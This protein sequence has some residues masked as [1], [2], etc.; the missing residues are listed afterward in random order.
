[1]NHGKTWNTDYGLIPTNYQEVDIMPWHINFDLILCHTS[2]ER[3][4]VAKQ[5]QQLFNIPIVRHTHV[6]PDIRFD[7][8]SQIASF[9]AIEVDHDSFIS[10]YNMEEWGKNLSKTTSFIEHG[11]DTDFW[12][13]GDSYDRENVCISVV[14]DWPNRDWCC[15][16]NLWQET[17]RFNSPDQLPIK[18]LGSSPGLSEPAPSLEALRE[19]YKRSSIFLNTSIHSPVPT[20]LMEAMAC[21]CAIVSTDNCMIPEIIQDGENGFLA[22]TEKEL[23]SHC[24]YL[25]NNPDEARRLGDNAKATIINEFNLDRFVESWNKQFFNVIRNYRK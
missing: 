20:V 4:M 10:R 19:E 6:L 2:C 7:P 13:G 1:M 21:G 16:W 11:I 22:N 25:L 24:E 15:G 23:R 5:I 14:N 18:V 3:I 17:V 8:Q 12:G 9:N